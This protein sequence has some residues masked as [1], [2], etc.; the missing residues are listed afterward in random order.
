[1]QALLSFD[2]APPLAAPLRFFLTAPV[3]AML[4]GILILSIGPQ[5]FVSRWTAPVL[6]ATHLFTLGF[7]AQVIIGAMLQILPVVAGANIAHPLPVARLVHLLLVAGT[8]ALVAA[9]LTFD[10]WAF[11]TAGWL[12]GGSLATFFLAAAHALFKVRSSNP[13]IVGLQLSLVGLFGTVTLGLLLVFS[14]GASWP[15]PLLQLTALHF[16]WGVVGWGIVLLIAVALVVVPMFQLTPAY[17]KWLAHTFCPLA[18]LLLT[19]QMLA[20]L[21]GWPL[22]ANVLAS[23]LAMGVA[24]FAAQTLRLQRQSTRVRFDASQHFWHLAMSC[25]LA[26]SG[27]WLGLLWLPELFSEPA[28][29]LF[30][31]VL[32]FIGGFMSVMIGMLY[33]IVPFLI[34]LHLQNCCPAGMMAPNMN[35]VIAAR[36]IDRQLWAHG[37]ALLLLLAAVVWPVWFA[38]LAGVAL[39]FA[40]GWLLRN[41]LAALIFYRLQ[42]ARIAV[43]ARE[44]QT[45]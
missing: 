4:V 32:I 10:T 28:W 29:I 21:S 42:A 7:L 17:P 44:V 2:Q 22:S 19:L 35:K 36:H 27:L 20:D 23:I 5:V 25:G 33:K 39:L 31:G 37:A 15:L 11:K 16:G 34:W 43:A 18:L 45:P 8:L 40:N 12:L 30:C 3:F 26:A 9:F 1:M 24:V 13:T 41:L 14:L 38:Y 6:A